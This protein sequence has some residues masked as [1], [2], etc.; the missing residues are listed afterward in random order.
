MIWFTA[1]ELRQLQ[2][3]ARLKNAR[4]KY[5]TEDFTADRHVRSTI[6]DSFC[7]DVHRNGNVRFPL[8]LHL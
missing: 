7:I 4:G 1:H 5:A 6:G 3:L 8:K 2:I